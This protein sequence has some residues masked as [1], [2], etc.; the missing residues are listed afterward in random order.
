MQRWTVASNESGVKLLV[1]LK[2]KLAE[3]Y[4]ARQLKKGI[5]N[6]L[7]RIN[8]RT[9]RFASA[10]L[11][12]GDVVEFRIE[13][14]EGI[15]SVEL[16]VDAQRI[17]YENEALLVYDKPFGIASDDSFTKLLRSYHPT[18][19]LVHR[20][21]RETTGAVIFAKKPAI[22]Q[23]MIALF[24]KMSVKKEY[25]ALVDGVPQKKGGVIE[26][27]LGKL[28]SY[29]GQ[30][31][32]GE[33]SE[34]K[35]LY[36]KTVWQCLKKGKAASLFQCFPETGRTHQIRVH[37]SGIGHPILGDYQYGREFRCPY[38]SKRILLHAKEVAFPHPET[39]I[40]LR[41]AAPIPA[42]FE[43]AQLAVGCIFEGF[44]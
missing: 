36:A 42:D 25:Y 7:C 1:F 8:G 11:G 10:P 34:K 22:K 27:Y 4:S 12:A 2:D 37:L 44:S 19:E 5:E 39:G 31:L 33:V 24:K 20:L 16:K 28:H 35:G 30:T 32:W 21:D 17:L 29:E 38:R 41:V 40:E 9:E 13:D 3:N 43:Q 15:P 14:L 23:A 6:N 18:L 26:N